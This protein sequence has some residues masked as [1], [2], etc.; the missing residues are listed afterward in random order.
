MYRKNK[1]SYP[2]QVYTLYIFFKRLLKTWRIITSL[3]IISFKI[4]ESGTNDH[5]DNTNYRSGFIIKNTIYALFW[6][7]WE[8]PRFFFLT[9]DIQYKVYFRLEIWKKGG[10]IGC[11][12]S[13]AFENAKMTLVVIRVFLKSLNSIAVLIKKRHLTKNFREIFC[14]STFQTFAQT[15]PIFRYFE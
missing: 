9:P 5:V 10:V 12:I 11:N 4:F 6:R 8:K 3:I 15:A 2:F 13:L 7:E 1:K 14:F